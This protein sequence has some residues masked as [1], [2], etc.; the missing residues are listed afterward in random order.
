V[1]TRSPLGRP[2]GLR[3]PEHRCPARG[4]A[5]KDDRRE[6][7]GEPQERTGRPG[8]ARAT[9]DPPARGSTPPGGRDGQLLPWDSPTQTGQPRIIQLAVTAAALASPPRVVRAGGRVS[10]PPAAPSGGRC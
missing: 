1:T 8:A 7:R 5:E 10:A 2:G 4:P 3:A 6:R 9:A